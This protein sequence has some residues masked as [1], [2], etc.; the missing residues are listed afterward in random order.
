M[1][2]CQEPCDNFR[3]NFLKLTDFFGRLIVY[4]FQIY[5]TEI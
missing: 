4:N 2:D 3:F 5:G 1:T